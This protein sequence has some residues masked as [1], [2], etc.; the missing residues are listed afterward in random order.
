MESKP[1]V[2][3]WLPWLGRVRFLVITF[4]VGVVVAVHQLTPVVIPVRAF[5]SLIVFWYTLA[6]VY[7]ILRRWIPQARWHAPLQVVCDLVI[8]TGVVYATG[9]QDSYFLSL[10]LLVILMSSVLFSRR[11]AFLVAGM[12]F[13]LLGCVIEL[14]Y[15]GV[16]ARTSNSM[17]AARSL[18]FWLAS[19]LFAFCA[20]AYLGSLLSQTLRTK[21][22]ELAEKSEELKDLQAFNQDIIESMRGGLLTT[23]LNGKILLMNRAGAE[24]AGLG[25]GLLRGEQVENV[26]PGF[27]PVELDE[28]GSPVALRK[29]IEFHTPDGATRYVGLS[30]SPLRLTQNQTSGYV[31]NFQDLTELKRLERE[32]VTKERMAA[33]GRLSAAIAHEIRQPLT[34]MTGA[35]KELARLAPLEDDDKKLVHIVSRESQRLNQIITDFLNYSRE[36][37]YSFVEVDLAAI[38]EETLTLIERD[39][40]A[41]GK[42]RI[43]RQFAARNIRARADR[44]ALK[45]VFWNLCNNALRAMPNGGVLTVSLDADPAWTRISIRD[46]G[47]GLDTTK[48]ST[49]FEPFQSGFTGGTGLGLAIVYQILQAHQGRI[50]VEAEKGSGAEFIV[51]LP[52]AV[53]TRTPSRSERLEPRPELLS[54]AGR[55]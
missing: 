10:Y 19:N 16:I 45:Q 22:V 54:S 48:A 39:A 42:F 40:S 38:I 5:I 2:S 25:F 31:F 43:E 33:L 50:R 20:V 51:E 34:A 44:D 6:V 32:V 28:Q 46:T 9:G 8:V 21:G 18:G 52:R 12:G 7:V 15:Y 17:P 1:S 36:K 49:L 47:I 27:W 26:L 23:D 53:R 13:V 29:E 37:T 3:E 4:L 11:G 55:G 35:L 14:M 41:L 24:I 30:V